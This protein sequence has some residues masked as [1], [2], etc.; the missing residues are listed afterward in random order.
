MPE[1]TIA[2][3]FQAFHMHVSYLFLIEIF[4]VSS[5]IFS[6]KIFSDETFELLSSKKITVSAHSKIKSYKREKNKCEN[7]VYI[8]KVNK[9]KKLFKNGI[10][11][12]Q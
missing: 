4:L 12:F 1:F 2:V 5:T 9:L 6:K 8:Y 10:N 3:L 7:L 11:N